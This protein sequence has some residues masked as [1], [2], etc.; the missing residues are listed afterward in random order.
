[1]DNVLPTQ[2]EFRLSSLDMTISR[3][4]TV[5]MIARIDPPTIVDLRGAFEDDPI[6][7]GLVDELDVTDHLYITVEYLSKSKIEIGVAIISYPSLRVKSTVKTH[8]SSIT[9]TVN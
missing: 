8:P 3:M 4:I 1:M 6:K 2:A 9:F 7:S 5:K